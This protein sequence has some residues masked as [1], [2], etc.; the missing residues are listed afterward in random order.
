MFRFKIAG[1]LIKGFTNI[2]C[3]IQ[4]VKYPEHFKHQTKLADIDKDLWF[5]M[6][7]ENSEQVF[8]IIMS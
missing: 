5:F 6:F 1:L 8:E 4:S 7:S 2:S 3:L